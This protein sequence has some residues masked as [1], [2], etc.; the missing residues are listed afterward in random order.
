MAAVCALDPY[1]DRKTKLRD[2]S[3]FPGLHSNFV[4]KLIFA[5]THLIHNPAIPPM[6]PAFPQVPTLT[7]PAHTNSEVSYCL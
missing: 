5:P 7:F 6:C 2:A 1:A 4:V 3:D